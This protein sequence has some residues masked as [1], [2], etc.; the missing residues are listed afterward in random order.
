MLN[1][2]EKYWS[3][4]QTY[5]LTMSILRLQ[6]GGVAAVSVDGRFVF[7]SANHRDFLGACLGTG[8]ER[9]KVGDILVVGETG[10]HI[11]IAPDLVEHLEASLTQACT[12]ETSSPF[13]SGWPV[14]PI[15]R[16]ILVIASIS[17]GSIIF[18]H[19]GKTY[20]DV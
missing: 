7:D 13:I 8:I 3:H 6:N 14:N 9:G 12:T 18:S 20:P 16:I 17:F 4:F 5:V 10:A 1:L 11:M 19:P 15:W 2:S